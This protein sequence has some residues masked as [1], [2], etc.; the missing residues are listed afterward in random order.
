MRDWHWSPKEKDVAR[1]AF[2]LAL[3]RE[4]DEVVRQ[5]KERAAGIGDIDQVWDLAYWLIKRRKQIDEKYDYRYSVLPDVFAI[6]LS[7]NE[8]GEDQLHGLAQ[9]KLDAIRK[10]RSHRVSKVGLQGAEGAVSPTAG[11]Y[12][13]IS[14]GATRCVSPFR[15]FSSILP[16]I[17]FPLAVCS[18]LVTEMSTVRPIIFRA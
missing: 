11:G 12:R 9:E 17:I 10:I 8:I 5:T 13:E 4:K 16:K 14:T 7:R 18:T 15:G 6:L 1:Q 3:G 2:E